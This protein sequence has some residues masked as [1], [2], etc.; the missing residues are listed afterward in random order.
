MLERFLRHC[1]WG[2]T[3]IEL[4]V[5]VA[6]IAILAAML[7]PALAAAREKARRASCVNNI[8]QI[9][10]AL[11]SYCSDYNQYFPSWPGVGFETPGRHAMSERGLYTDVRLGATV[12]TSTFTDDTAGPNETCSYADVVNPGGISCFRS[13]ACIAYDGNS[14]DPVPAKPQGTAST[15]RMAPVNLG[16]LLEA[17]YIT[18][19]TVFY[20][21]T[22]RGM[23]C[24]GDPVKKNCYQGWFSTQNI[25]Q[26]KKYSK[27]T[28]PK[29]LFYG[30]YSTADWNQYANQYGVDGAT[31]VV[32]GQYNYRG[33]IY[34]SYNAQADCMA[35]SYV[36]GTRPVATGRYCAQIFAT[37]KKLGNRALICDAFEKSHVTSTSPQSD[38][39]MAARQSAGMQTHRDGYNVAYGDGHVTW[40]GDPQQK[41]I[42]WT[43]LHY[44]YKS[45]NMHS[46]THH[47]DWSV[48][49]YTDPR[50]N[51][52]SWWGPLNHVRRLNGGWAVWHLMDTSAG[53]DV[54]AYWRFGSY[55]N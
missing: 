4:L 18:D 42:W 16:Y 5:V 19:W 50:F 28:D 38:I 22:A 17:R 32:A 25:S 51:N 47:Y 12:Q 46:G 3:L 21:P 45:A 54:D 14:G 29:D 53:V 34:G 52:P 40:Y 30:D 10:L 7:L 27:S 11:F 33:V 26:L 15:G 23:V 35:T 41:I 48:R 13:L 55:P 44:N 49:G 2:F 20:C 6:I 36:G 31:M 24:H 37:Q 9:N 1:R 8:K 43:A 39:T